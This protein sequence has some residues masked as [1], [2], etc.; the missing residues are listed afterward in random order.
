MMQR[1]GLKRMLVFSGSANVELAE[2]VVK[3]LDVELGGVPGEGAQD[4]APFGLVE[5]AEGHDLCAAPAES[6]VHLPAFL[7]RPV[8]RQPKQDSVRRSLLLGANRSK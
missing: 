6:E 8:I 2:E 7:N 1:P 4:R 5:P 3:L